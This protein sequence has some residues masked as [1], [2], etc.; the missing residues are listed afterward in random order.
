[1]ID[2]LVHFKKANGERVGK[3]FKWKKLTLAP[4]ERVEIEKAHAIKPITTR[5]YYSGK[6]GL[7]LRINGADFG[8]EEFSLKMP[9]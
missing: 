7:S 1:M 5:R 9:K 6:Q 2:Y 4:G 8:F 3:V